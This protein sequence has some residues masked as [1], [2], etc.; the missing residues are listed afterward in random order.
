MICIC[1]RDIHELAGKRVCLFSYGSGLASS[2]Y[3]LRISSNARPGSS[4]NRLV[5]NLSHIKPLLDQRKRV[6]PEEFAQIM[7]IREQNH[8]K[9]KVKYSFSVVLRII[10]HGIMPYPNSFVSHHVV[11][12]ASAI[13]YTIT[14]VEYSSPLPLKV[15]SSIT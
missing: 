13:S 4:L 2:M 6:T 9:G 5:E 3:S 8:H 12:G 14:V 15:I 10:T 7:E 11:F 1:S